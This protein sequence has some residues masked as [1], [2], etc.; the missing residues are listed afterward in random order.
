MEAEMLEASEVE[1][2]EL[3]CAAGEKA[4]LAS[5]SGVPKFN[6][7]RM[8]GVLQRHRVL[9]LIDGGSSHNFIDATLLKRRHIPTIEFEGFKVEVAGG[10]TMPYNRYISGMKLTL[11]RHELVQDVYVMDLPDTNTILGVQWLNTFGPITTNYKTM[12]M[13]FVE[14]GGRKVVLRGMTGNSARVVTAKR[15]EAIFRREEIV[16]P[17]ECKV[18]TWVDEKKKMHYTPEIKRIL[19][20]HQKLFRPIP[21]GVPPDRGFEHI[22]ELEPGAKPVITIPYKH[23]KK[24]KDEIDKAIK[25]LLDMGHIRPSSSPFASSV[26]LVKKKDGTM[27]MCI[28]L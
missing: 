13:S 5:I 27:R 21:L 3:D 23:P 2:L 9:V 18:S 14:E 22:I 1:V 26:V 6:T 24:Y 19:D 20:K 12:E 4:M 15:M 17:V 7:F 11:G 28:D 25:E 16:Y 8:R 10:S